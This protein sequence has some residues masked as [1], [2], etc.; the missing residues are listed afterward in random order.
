VFVRSVFFGVL[1]VFVLATATLAGPKDDYVLGVT[2]FKSL[3]ANEKRAGLRA[4]WEAVMKPFQRSLAAQ[5]KG[6]YAP[7]CMYFLGRSYEELARRSFAKADRKAALD[8]FDRMLAAFPKHE[9][10]DDSLYRKG[11]IWQE[12]AKDSGQ[13]Q[14]VFKAVMTT[15][16]K[17]D[18][19]PEAARRLA[20][21][22]SAATPAASATSAPQPPSS[23]PTKPA[24]LSRESSPVP[25][26]KASDPADGPT[27]L[28]IRHW[29]SHDYTRVVMDVTGDVKYE[30]T[31]VEK[32][33]NGGKQLQITLQRTTIDKDVMPARTIQDGIL[34]Q[35]QVRGDAL[36]GA[37]ITFDLMQMNNY[38]VFTLPEPYR[39]VLDIYGGDGGKSEPVAG[40]ESPAPVAEGDVDHVQ[41]A[42]AELQAKQQAAAPQPAAPKQK[43]A[44]ALPAPE[45]TTQPAPT[46]KAEK[47]APEQT[48]NIAVSAK[49]K[50][51]AGTLVEQLGL[52]VRTIMIDA[53]HGGKDP[54]A[55]A[56]G[57][58]EKNINLRMAK[59][60][61][62]MLKDQGF[63]V[64]YTRTT[65]KFL[66]LEERTAMAN[67]KNA[68]LFI[69]L[70]CNA[71]KDQSVKG[72]EVYYLNLAT[73]AQAVRVAAR[74]NGVSAKKI[75]DMQ[76]I[77][78]DLMLNSKINESRQMAALIEKETLRAVRPKFALASHGSKGAFFYVLTGA[79]M[80]S[81]LV[82][83]GYLTNPDE[84]AKL[85]SEA[86]LTLMAKGLSSG[87]MAYKKK[88][89]QFA[90][91]S[92]G[93]S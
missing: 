46:P 63:E 73:D 82:E 79:R 55:V 38:R 56:H 39:V 25:V 65:D 90:L 8:A 33:G 13:A 7:K 61:G 9:W 74:E 16:P 53:G 20:E 93:T 1:L 62:G 36:G 66:P 60:L 23:A 68:D 67:A 49:Q 52:K 50:K 89:E 72:L 57:V 58:Q 2:A 27:L 35:I 92:S 77:L 75:S 14:A 71:Y 37:L 88:L 15:Y 83:L 29:S 28:G 18:M 6:E 24:P 4:E 85:N 78:S 30:R 47:A 40:V 17:G 43:V 84:A 41:A 42:L 11:L 5:P 19:A 34:S 21:L 44:T 10:A 91:I 80:P 48:P 76:F 22:Q 31:L 26:Q 64:H 87:V 69:S 86:Y 81:I 70:H 3:L 32:A 12:Q 45:A 54:G 59:L 51:Y